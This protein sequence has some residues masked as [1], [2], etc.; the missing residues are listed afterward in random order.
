MC[1]FMFKASTDEITN[2]YRRLSRMYHPDKCR[3]PEKQV[4]A[5]QLFE[6]AKTAHE[7]MLTVTAKLYF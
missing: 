5:R 3:D 6:K 2:Q 7:S 4:Y 1:H